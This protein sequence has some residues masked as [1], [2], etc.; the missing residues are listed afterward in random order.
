MAIDIIECADWNDFKNKIISDL[1]VEG[2][3]KKGKYLFRGQ[4]G[5]NWSLSS[6]FDRWYH[7][8]L[9]NKAETAKELLNQFKME[10]ELEDL[11]DNVR[12]ND[13]M[14]M[15]LGQH[16]H[17]PTRLLDWSESPYVSAFFAF[18]LHVRATEE[19]S[20][21][22]A[23][24]VLNTSDPI[25]NPEFGCEIV[26]VPSFGNERIKNQHGK[27]THL[28]TLESSIEEYVERYPKEGR[29]IKYVLPAR[30][31]VNALSDL[32]SMGI[33]FARIYPGIYGNAMSA[34]IRVLAK[35]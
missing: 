3:F 6:S 13:I 26:N 16:H 10:C 5:E 20:S 17:L 32:D 21:K 7:G 23:I 35:L 22:V 28:K 33:N 15:S 27:F 30:D 12:N 8:E 2:R 25:W 1:Y 11:P 4:G 14:M 34:Q 9:K 18:S 29:L 24:W 19:S 31:A